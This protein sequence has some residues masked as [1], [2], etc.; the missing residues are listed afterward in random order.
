[1]VFFAFDSKAKA[2]AKE[3]IE[4]EK[5]PILCFY[6]HNLLSLTLPSF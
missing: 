6:A 4:G 1:L 5:N 3:E 2:K